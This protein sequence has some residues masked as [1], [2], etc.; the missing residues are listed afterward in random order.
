M[1]RREFC[2]VLAGAA[3]SGGLAAMATGAKPARKPNIVLIYADD[4]GWGDV[5]YHGVKDIVT[6]NIDALAA[7]GMQMAQGYV[8]ASVCGPSRCGLLT[9]VHQQRFGCGANPPEKGWPDNPRFPLAG[10]P[11]SQPILPQY[12]KKVGY[13]TGVIGKWH[14][15]IHKTMRPLK[16]GFD[17]FYGFLNGAHSYTRSAATFVGNASL[18]PIFEN[19]RIVKFDG[20]LT[21]VFADKAV[22]FIR[23]NKTKPFFLYHAPNAVHAPWEVPEPYLKR[24]RHI[25]PENRRLYAA[26]VLALDD[27]VGR[28]MKTLKAE[29]LADNTIVM[30]ISDNGP[31]HGQKPINTPGDQMASAG[32]LR[33]WKG[34]CYEGGIRVPF[35]INWPGVLKPGSRYDQP[36]ITLD[37]MPTLLAHLGMDHSGQGLSF[38]GTNLLPHLTGKKTARPHDILYWRRDSDYAI[39][40]GDW[41][42][43]WND[44]R[45]TGPNRAELF[46]LAG[47]PG[48]RHDLIKKRPRIASELQKLFDKWDSRLPDSRWWGRPANRKR[49]L[50]MKS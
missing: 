8:S 41:K 10:L 3:V 35:V 13:R 34:D 27:S 15:G 45:P 28:I 32:P 23:R 25:I 22:D 37:I 24:V 46:D 50:R 1:R 30:F 49:V 33:G 48:E 21:D 9:G 47:D 29:G 42:L 36:V 39:R 2:K 43:T 6:P 16:R 44:G 5:G 19:D 26:M 12:L 31:P 11:L 14:L 20:Y 18:W 4:M 7:G 38:D 17:E 40:R